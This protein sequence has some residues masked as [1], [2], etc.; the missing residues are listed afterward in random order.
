MHRLDLT[1]RRCEPYPS[2]LFRGRQVDVHGLDSDPPW[3]R[4]TVEH[5]LPRAAED[6]GLEAENLRVHAHAA[7]AVDPSARLDVDLLAGGQH[8][9]ENVAV[10]VEP[11]HTLTGP[12]A[13]LVDEKP[14]RAKD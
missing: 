13:E 12:G 5:H 8:L 7:V 9:V 14:G 11:D 4:E 3:A 6:A 10:T 2:N 1:P